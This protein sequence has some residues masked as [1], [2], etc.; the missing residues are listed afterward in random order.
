MAAKQIDKSKIKIEIETG[1]TRNLTASWGDA[2]KIEHTKAFKYEW[3]HKCDGTWRNGGSGTTTEVREADLADKSKQW[4]NLQKNCQD[5]APDNATV[6]AVHIM[7]VSDTYKKKDKNGNE[8]ETEYYTDAKWSDWKNFSDWTA[9]TTA[10]VFQIDAKKDDFG[11]FNTSAINPNSLRATFILSKSRHEKFLLGLS[12]FQFRWEMYNGYEWSDVSAFETYIHYT[13]DN[14]G[15]NAT[16]TGLVHSGNSVIVS[17]NV[18]NAIRAGNVTVK[19]NSYIHPVVTAKKYRFSVTPDTSN[20]Y[21]FLPVESSVD[22]TY[23]AEPLQLQ[24]DGINI[25]Y[26]LDTASFIVSW[27]SKDVATYTAEIGHVSGFQ[28]EW[29][30]VKPVVSLWNAAGTSWDADDMWAE[31]I[32]E[33]IDLDNRDVSHESKTADGTG[34]N[35]DGWTIVESIGGA[36]RNPMASSGWTVVETINGSKKSSST[37]TKP[38]VID[39]TTYSWRYAFQLPDGVRQ[40]STVKVRIKVLGDGSQS[41]AEEWS[42]WQYFTKEVPLRQI[43]AIR[44]KKPTESER[45]LDARWTIKNAL[46]VAGFTYTWYYAYR[47]DSTWRILQDSA[48]IDITR[49]IRGIVPVETILRVHNDDSNWSSLGNYTMDEMLDGMSAYY[50]WSA[51]VDAPAE[52]SA[53]MVEIT[54]IPSYSGAFVGDPMRSSYDITIP[55]KFVPQSSISLRVYD[56]SERSLVATWSEP[57]GVPPISSTDPAGVSS[58]DVMWEIRR[59]G[60]WYNGQSGSAASRIIIDSAMPIV[61]NS[62]TFSVPNTSA[63]D[64]VRFAIKPVAKSEDIWLGGWSSY[65]ALSV[66]PTVVSPDEG[67]LKITRMENESRTFLATFSAANMFPD[68]GWSIDTPT[69]NRMMI[70]EWSYSRNGILMDPNQVSTRIDY[71]YSTFELPGNDDW[72]PDYIR[73]RVKPDINNLNYIGEWSGYVSYSIYRP[74]YRITDLDIEVFDPANRTILSEWS[75]YDQ[76]K[77]IAN[78]SYQWRYYRNGRWLAPTGGDT[79]YSDISTD[80]IATFDAPAGASHVSFRI[81]AE[82]KY[83]LDF[84]G[85]WSNQVVIDVPE[86]TIPATCDVPNVSILADG[87]TIRATVDYYDTRISVIEFQSIDRDGYVRYGQAQY[88]ANVATWQFVGDGGQ[89]YKVRARA[90]NSAGEYRTPEEGDHTSDPEGWSNWS[91]EVGTRPA[92]VKITSCKGL[93]AS[94]IQVTWADTGVADVLTNATSYIVERATKAYYFDAAPNEVTSTTVSASGG[95]YAPKQLIVTGLTEGAT[96]YFRVAALRNESGTTL[97]SEWSAL[98]SCTIGKPPTAPTTW[99]NQTTGMIGD[100]I[101][102]YWTHNSEDNS[103]ESTAQLQIIKNGV[104]STVN[105]TRDEDDTTQRSYTL[106]S[107][108]V[109]SEATIQW[110]V[111]TKGAVNEYSPWST[112]RVI[113]IY[114]MPSLGISLRRLNGLNWGTFVQNSSNIYTNITGITALSRNIMTGFPLFVSFSASPSSQTPV[115][116]N[117]TITANV[118]YEGHDAVGNSVD[119][120][121][122]QIIFRRYFNTSNR[123]FTT[124][125]TPGDVDFVS[126]TSYTIDATVAMD[127]GLSASAAVRFST[128]WAEEDFNITASIGVDRTRLTAYIRPYCITESTNGSYSYTGNVEMSVYRREFDGGF[129]KIADHISNR[130]RPTITDPHPNLDF[131]RYRVVA[132]SESTG[133]MTYEDLNPVPIGEHAIILQ[134]DETWTSYVD[135]EDLVVEGVSLNTWTGSMVRLPYNVDTTDSNTV[136][137]EMV[138]YIGRSHPVSYYGTQVGQKATWT[139][140]IPKTD[141][142]TIYDLRRLARYMGNVYVRE[143]SGTGY[144]AHVE[145][146][147]NITHL[148]TTIPVNLAITR[149]EGGV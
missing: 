77:P 24:K 54:P 32:S 131:A 114:T 105:L 58:Y 60:T 128:S 126:G 22:Y 21:I 123:S 72:E 86:D 43:H 80:N 97:Q 117:I 141:K 90:L 100:T 1:T 120:L 70:F 106:P 64:M 89:V 55:V 10:P 2:K 91:S 27:E 69:E 119:V 48:T 35:D 101:I 118:G 38:K 112:Q 82:P 31:S 76:P 98:A 81:K 96:W 109:N 136:D 108:Y 25:K 17:D 53:V 12:S 139:A 9:T 11:I 23:S 42:E 146:S 140:L 71:P 73:V 56:A 7:P 142:Q 83:D 16:G 62:S 78:Y 88:V 41:F 40:D 110:R 127:S 44:I 28:L 59:D 65:V 135:N 6:S 138:E 15:R 124:I 149:V 36:N 92:P 46:Y 47:G 75:S 19:F 87:Y 115:A 147:F 52:A 145:V 67:Y 93:T 143:P 39:T 33:T 3:R 18:K 134:W 121:P 84:K 79:E 103:A 132:V 125:I 111:R 30:Y 95:G 113:K 94:S 14:D 116:Y 85:E 133:R 104:T 63:I 61:A 137:V 74:A 49:T 4:S 144:W 148:E 34:N 66:K 26:D 29:S 13:N 37:T 122:G 8:T 68:G 51:S 50:V 20:A 5:T 99:S 107:S 57:T 102:L 45:K 129:T 130:I